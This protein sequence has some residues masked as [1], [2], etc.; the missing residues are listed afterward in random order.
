MNTIIKF[1]IP[2][3]ETSNLNFQIKKQLPYILVITL[4]LCIVFLLLIPVS[5]INE[6]GKIATI[7]Y[8]FFALSIIQ[9]VALILIRT[10]NSFQLH[11]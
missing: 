2:H 1:F 9:L 10:E 5:M 7:T 3:L 6:N 8:I 4:V 11:G